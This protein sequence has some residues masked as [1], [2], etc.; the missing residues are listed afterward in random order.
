MSGKSEF[1]E[2]WNAWRD[3]M[4]AQVVA[5]CRSDPE[6]LD[7]VLKE[8]KPL[9]SRGRSTSK[10]TRARYM[11]VG[12]ELAAAL[13][14]GSTLEQAMEMSAKTHGVTVETLE[15]KHLTKARKTMPPRK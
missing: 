4:L 7:R 13:E 14:A 15:K 3:R 10:W 12:Q 6:F 11:T 5:E 2:A 8:L 9:R 1:L